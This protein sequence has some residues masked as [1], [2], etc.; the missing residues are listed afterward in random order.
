MERNDGRFFVFLAHA[1]VISVVGGIVGLM[2]SG[3]S[4][5]EAFRYY[6]SW[7]VWAVAV[8]TVFVLHGTWAVNSFAHFFGYRNYET[9]DESRNNWMVAL[10]SHG[11]GWHNNHH[12]APRAA[13]H[14]HK[15]YEFDMSWYVI[16]SW[17]MIGLA[18]NVQ[19]PKTGN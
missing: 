10:F 11:E 16:R 3:G 6:C 9:R 15:W 18:K 1:I 5:N 19:R 13:R 8:R 4:W 17:E 12:A 2:V 14:G 7:A